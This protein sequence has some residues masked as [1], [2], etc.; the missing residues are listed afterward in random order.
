MSN[1]LLDTL[2]SQLA[3]ADDD[4]K[5]AKAQ[6]DEL[7]Q[8]LIDELKE[9]GKTKFKGTFG[10][11]CLVNKTNYEFSNNVVILNEQLKAAKAIEQKTGVATI[12]SVTESIRV[13][14][15]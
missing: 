15:S 10:S 14:F 6:V 7:R 4:L 11:I 5:Q 13:T 12:S 8:L 9:Q 3:A 2:I 1:N